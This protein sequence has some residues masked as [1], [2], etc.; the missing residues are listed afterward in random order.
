MSLSVH[1][2]VFESVLGVSLVW[3][4]SNAWLGPLE[5]DLEPEKAFTSVNP[6]GS[7]K[8]NASGKCVFLALIGSMV[9]HIVPNNESYV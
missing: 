6:K 3:T 7:A 9:N 8:R 4:F 1:I 5:L 2:N